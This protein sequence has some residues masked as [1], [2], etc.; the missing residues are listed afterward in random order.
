MLR[1]PMTSVILSLT[2]AT[3]L[4]AQ[5]RQAAPSDWQPTAPGTFHRITEDGRIESLT[6]GRAGYESELG[7]LGRQIDRLSER[8]EQTAAPEI[9]DA[10][11]A[12]EAR[13]DEVRSELERYDEETSASERLQAS[14]LTPHEN[15]V[16]CTPSAWVSAAAAPAVDGPSSRATISYQDA[17]NNDVFGY[18]WA[19]AEGYNGSTYAYS[20][21]EQ[22]EIR[23]VGGLW[24]DLP[25]HVTNVSS[26]CIAE[27]YARARY[28][29]E[30][31]PVT[32][33]Q[34]AV[35]YE[36]LALTVVI[37]G[38]TSVTV[39]YG[40]CVS[41][42]FTARPNLGGVSYVWNNAPW[43]NG[44]AVTETYCSDFPRKP[45][46]HMEGVSVTA[47]TATQTASDSHLFRLS[48]Q[49]EPYDPE[50]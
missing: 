13:R 36:C 22:P 8:Y 33:E 38:P 15:L 37:D 30:K 1:I 17:C 21:I 7:H 40:D 28:E 16:D 44:Q 47:S 35:S 20:F 6:Y 42:T 34:Y 39:P 26:G 25:A 18:G 45:H 41:V 10:L 50:W 5:P 24:I 2:L 31:V 19:S 23:G 48:F 12:L 27:S 11:A 4:A 9:L 14:T 32:L 46:S 3:T 49:G 29:Y 43:E